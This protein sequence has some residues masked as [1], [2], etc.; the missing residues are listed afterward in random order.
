MLIWAYDSLDD[1]SDNYYLETPFGTVL[2]FSRLVLLIIFGREIYA[3]YTNEKSTVKGTFY[4][5]FALFGVLFI[6]TMPVAYL[7]A[8]SVY[9]YH[10]K[11]TDFM[12]QQIFDIL[13]YCAL[14]FFFGRSN[15]SSYVATASDPSKGNHAAIN[16]DD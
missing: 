12:V 5:Q 8:S 7:I 11:K 16:T 2:I 15:Y 1:D 4:K 3:T 6:L 9:S 10:R 13:G 14:F